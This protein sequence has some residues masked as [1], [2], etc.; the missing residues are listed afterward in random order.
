[1]DLNG[2]ASKAEKVSRA[3]WTWRDAAVKP[4]PDRE[5]AALRRKAFVQTAVMAV[6]GFVLLHFKKHIGAGVIFSLALFLLASAFFFPAVFRAVDKF[7]RGF[8][9]WT[10]IAMTWLLLVPFFYLTFVPG[11]IWILLTGKDPL[12][13]RFPSPSPTL[14]VPRPPVKD[15]GQ[16]RKQF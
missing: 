10:A 8:G 15:P 16:Y 12:N 6:A 14:W 13:R 3:V 2:T 4:D 9:H 5:A 11:R 7:A 1:M